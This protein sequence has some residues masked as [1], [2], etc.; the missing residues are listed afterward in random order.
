MNIVVLAG[1]LSPERDVSLSGAA[2]ACNTLLSSGHKAVLVDLFFG[3][4]T[5]PPDIYSVFDAAKPVPPYRVSRTEPDLAA[6]A[7]ARKIGYDEK[8][9]LNV[10]ELC[11]ACDI[12]YMALHGDVG[13]NG[14]LQ[15]LFDA[16]GIRYTGSGAEGCRLAMDKWA[17]KRIFNETGL[18][19]PFG[20]RLK[21]GEPCPELELPC[22][23]KPNSGGSSIGI[24][25]VREPDELEAALDLAFEKEDEIIIEQYIK[26]RE[27]S[28]GV[29]DGAA[30][31]LIE[32]IPHQGFYDYANKYQ[33]NAVTEQTPAHVD[34]AATLRAQELSVKA[35]HALQ[36]AVYARMDL[37]MT[38]AGEWFLLEANTLPGMTPTSL[39]PQEAAAV[40]IDFS[41]LC[42]KI[43][44][45]SEEKYR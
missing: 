1:G 45:L 10:L 15:R 22:V 31:P 13:E 5:L 27:F 32:L 18:S 20:I 24:S 2:L 17:S 38:E 40:G 28:C 3:L 44:A 30:L 21:R 36:L 7:A 12:V 42:C 41:A 19:T 14:M 29:L 23:V 33:P 26:G 11:R 43:I 35:F 6:I 4:P 16:E 25:I 37:I 8:I 9:G 34:A 39:L